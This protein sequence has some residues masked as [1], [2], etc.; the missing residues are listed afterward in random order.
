MML[1]VLK[2]KCWRL[3]PSIYG[4]RQSGF[5]WNILLRIK[6]EKERVIIKFFYDSSFNELIYTHWNFQHGHDVNFCRHVITHHTNADG[7]YSSVEFKQ[8]EIHQ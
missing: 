7:K 4:L 5:E 8:K 6:K 1:V 2:G 3:K